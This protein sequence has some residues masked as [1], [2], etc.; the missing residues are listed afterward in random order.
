MKIPS[1]KLLVSK[2]PYNIVVLRQKIFLVTFYKFKRFFSTLIYFS[3]SNS[4]YTNFS[5]K[6]QNNISKMSLWCA[7]SLGITYLVYYFTI[8]SDPKNV[9]NFDIQPEG[10]ET[11]LK[12]LSYDIAKELQDLSF[13]IIS[14]VLLVSFLIFWLC[15]QYT[16][17]LNSRKIYSLLFCYIYIL[18]N[19]LVS[20]TSFPVSFT[21]VWLILGPIVIVPSV[22]NLHAIYLLLINLLLYHLLHGY[23]IEYYDIWTSIISLFLSI[24]II[25]LQIEY[26][27]REIRLYQY[28][29]HLKERAL[30]IELIKEN[31]NHG[32]MLLDLDLKVRSNFSDICTKLLHRK[33]LHDYYFP[34]LLRKIL[35]ENQYFINSMNYSKES[36]ER[37]D[38][39]IDDLNEWEE[40]VKHYFDM[41]RAEQLD[42][43]ELACIDPLKFIKIYS[44]EGR[45][46]ISFHVSAVKVQN[47]IQYFMVLISNDTGK[48]AGR[49]RIIEHERRLL[50]QAESLFMLSYNNPI[51]QKQLLYDFTQN[52]FELSQNILTDMRDTKPPEELIIVIPKQLSAMYDIFEV[53]NLYKYKE[54]SAKILEAFQNFQQNEHN[55]SIR[56]LLMDS[57]SMQ[58]NYIQLLAKCENFLLKL[59]PLFDLAVFFIREPRLMEELQ[60]QKQILH[61][62]FLNKATTNNPIDT[63]LDYTQ[64]NIEN[65]IFINLYMAFEILLSQS[66]LKY[67]RKPAEEKLPNSSSQY[68]KAHQAETIRTN[69]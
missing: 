38:Y 4:L 17:T 5:I 25:T 39:A 49:Y 14:P 13:H 51:Q 60:K 44:Y 9:L 61:K 53:C 12:N 11:F 45:N 29:N 42:D 8:I 24:F 54:Q 48:V 69:H 22:G 37:N 31:I 32:L 16:D 55:H 59:R 40:R 6:T 10:N 28:G 21:N 18:G 34:E 41:L 26:Y 64:L 68:A 52:Y 67:N 63:D 30:E 7:V 19:N 57:Q 66:D 27:R 33:N 36:L 23:K 3:P 62:E 65:Q 1:S 15:F 2:K 46:Y 35:E 20:L 47:D 50:E 43:Q 56:E 58:M